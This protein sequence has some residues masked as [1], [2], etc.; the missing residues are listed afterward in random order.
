MRKTRLVTP[1]QK[2]KILEL[3]KQGIPSETIIKQINASRDETKKAVAEIKESLGIKKISTRITLGD[4]IRK[5]FWEDK[6]VKEVCQI[7]NAK[8]KFAETIFAQEKRK[9]RDRI[10]PVAICKKC[11]YKTKQPCEFCAERE[12]RRERAQKIRQGLI[13]PFDVTFEED[14]EPFI[15]FEFQK[16]ELEAFNEIRDAYL[17]LELEPMSESA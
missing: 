3:V 16:R 8:T 9:I 15:G 2:N 4:K 10:N 5:L 14:R 12:K 11:G 13:K 17:D 7:L 1:D 6:K